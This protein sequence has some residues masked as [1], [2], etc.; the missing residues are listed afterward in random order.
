MNVV[1]TCSGTGSRLKPITDYLNKALIKLDDAAIISHIID[2]YPSDSKFI[3]TL[4]YK[5]E[6]VREYL[7]ILYPDIDINYVWVDDFD[8]PKSSLLYSLSKTFKYLDQPFFYNACDTLI[9]NKDFTN[10]DNNKIYIA[11]SPIDNQYRKV[12]I[13]ENNSVE[14][15]DNPA[16]AHSYCYTGCAY[17]KDYEDFI[18]KSNEMLEHEN[19]NSLSDA[20][21]LAKL[22]LD[23]EIVDNWIDIGN[24]IA[25]EM[26]KQKFKPEICVLPK[27]NQETYKVR[28]R[29][30][31]F[32]A[33]TK[34]VEKLYNRSKELELCAPKCLY[35]GNFLFYNYIEGETLSHILTPE[36]L[37]L[38]LEWCNDYLWMGCAQSE[39]N[40]FDKFYIQK[41]IDRV[42]L[43]LT[44][45]KNYNYDDMEINFRK[46]SNIYQLLETI[47][48][49]FKKDVSMSTCHGDLVFENVIYTDP[50]NKTFPHLFKLIDW[51]EGFLTNKGDAYYDIAKMKHNLIFDHA[52]IAEN[53][54]IV[55]FNEN[56][57]YFDPA[58]PEKNV[59]LIWV[60]DQWCKEW[61]YDIKTVDLLVALI[62]L[63]SSGVHTGQDS[64]LLF[65]MGW[66]NLQM[67]LNHA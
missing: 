2:S 12:N 64:H 32:F 17:I 35:S 34:K 58:M 10:L 43:Y 26:A 5:W 66:Y 62:Q 56:K 4:G 7:N 3:I 9:E 6:Q 20:H 29:I 60:L 31:K 8:G 67:V 45:N 28:G 47:P 21:I 49:D 25:L 50:K 14:L 11:K 23:C 38:F 36:L 57:C 41:A 44:A 46:M 1:I 27:K 30:I 24:P 33:D 54:F 13:N 37:R 40:F 16:E 19:S 22:P 15:M 52:S 55:K 48:E 42:H 39:E 63:S 53:K 51:R 65:Y 18:N 59:E 61:D